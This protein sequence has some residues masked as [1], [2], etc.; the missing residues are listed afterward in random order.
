[1]LLALKILQNEVDIFSLQM[2]MG[3]TDLQVLRRYLKL[4][5]SYLRNAHLPASPVSTLNI[6]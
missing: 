4:A 1:M 6:S 5:S 2:L 3:H